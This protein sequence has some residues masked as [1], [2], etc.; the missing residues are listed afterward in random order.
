MNNK[1]LA[2]QLKQVLQAV[3]YEQRACLLDGVEINKLKFII[4]HLEAAIDLL[5]VKEP[6][7]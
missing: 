4:D 6:W 1:E 5:E 7:V 2:E 3:Q